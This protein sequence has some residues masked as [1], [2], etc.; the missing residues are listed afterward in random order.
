M[1]PN[2]FKHR[3][4]A[5]DLKRVRS[6]IEPSLSAA[7][8][9][10]QGRNNPYPGTPV[11]L[12]LDY[13]RG[14]EELR[15]AWDRREDDQFIGF[16]AE[17]LSKTGELIIIATCTCRESPPSRSTRGTP[18]S[19]RRSTHLQSRSRSSWIVN[20]LFRRLS[21]R[22]ANHADLCRRLTERHLD[23]FHDFLTLGYGL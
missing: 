23:R 11:F 17:F 7:G 9:V 12:Y 18:L 1:D 10:F 14:Q 8:F 16:T 15:V 19:N 6:A 20:G 13:A 4:P 3:H 22:A 5:V 2:P 21:A